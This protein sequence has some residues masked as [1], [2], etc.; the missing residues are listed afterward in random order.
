[1]HRL[2]I[3]RQEAKVGVKINRKR[4]AL[5]AAWVAAL[6]LFAFFEGVTFGRTCERP[7]KGCVRVRSWAV[8]CPY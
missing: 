4:V 7:A 3:S 2:R 8:N 6:S 5:S 1:M